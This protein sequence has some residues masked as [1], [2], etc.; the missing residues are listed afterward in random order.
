MGDVPAGLYEHLLTTTLHERLSGVDDVLTQHEAL[1]PADTHEAL[2]RHIAQ[3]VSRALRGLSGSDQLAISRQVD[4]ANHMVKAITA[5]S[6]DTATSEDT[7]LDPGR[8]LL[9]VAAPSGTPG[10]PTFPD[11][12]EVPLST[13]ALLVNGRGQPRI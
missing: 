5:I 1:D 13:S 6:P 8:T 10:P 11:R 2:T 12:P 9:A 3:I 4:L 7:I